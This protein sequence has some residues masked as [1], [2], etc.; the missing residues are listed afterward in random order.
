MRQRF[1]FAL[2]LV[3]IPSSFAYSETFM[4]TLVK[5]EGSKVTYK[6][7]TYN[8][9]GGA[10]PNSL[11][12]YEMPVTVEVTKDAAI[13]RGHFLPAEDRNTSK[14]RLTGKTTPLEGGLS[15]GLFK[16]L[17]EKEKAPTRPSLITT[18]DEGSDKGKITAI[19][20]WSSA[21]PK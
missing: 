21:A 1:V 11:Y 12:R 6:K 18:A 17:L 14:G 3:A 8:P 9:D 16:R 7:A 5:V 20:L 10:D 19:N 2:A 13:T 4:A 15:N